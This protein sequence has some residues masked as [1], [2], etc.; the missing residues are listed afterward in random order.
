VREP[1]A[2]NFA[3]DYYLMPLRFYLVRELIANKKQK[4]LIATWCR[5][6]LLAIH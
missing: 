4:K 6:S 2:T 1:I 5:S 3:D